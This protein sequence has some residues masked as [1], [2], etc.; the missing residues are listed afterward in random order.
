MFD[1]PLFDDY[2]RV[3]HRVTLKLLN[4]I[5]LYLFCL[6]STFK[7]KFNT[8]TLFSVFITV[9]CAIILLVFLY[10]KLVESVFV[11]LEVIDSY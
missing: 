7:F 1:D 10:K 6:I 3:K 5:D 8:F 9:L 2:E 11:F 4:L